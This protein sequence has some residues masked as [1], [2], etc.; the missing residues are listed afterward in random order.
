MPAPN[1]SSSARARSLSGDPPSPPPAHPPSSAPAC[2]GKRLARKLVE[3]RSRMPVRFPPRA[4]PFARPSPRPSPDGARVYPDGAKSPVV[5]N[6][7]TSRLAARLV[8]SRPSRPDSSHPSSHPSASLRG[9][10]QANCGVIY[11]DEHLRRRD[12]LTAKLVS[13][14]SS[15]RSRDDLRFAAGGGGTVSWVAEL[16]HDARARRHAERSAHRHSQPRH[17]QRTRARHRLGRHLRWTSP[18][19]FVRDRGVGESDY[20]DSG[21]GARR[22]WKS[23][24]TDESSIDRGET[25]GRRSAR[26]GTG[27]CTIPSRERERVELAART[28]PPRNHPRR[29]SR[30]R[31]GDSFAVGTNAAPPAS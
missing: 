29:R 20:A 21:S 19:S 11:L 17:G 28:G 8:A 12:A 25:R 1:A 15:H 22:R 27:R 24:R 16:I 3:V 4:S 9:Y 26:W 5:E 10:S 13:L 31:G 7:S 14:V 23:V 30:A 18:R 6:I 2:Q